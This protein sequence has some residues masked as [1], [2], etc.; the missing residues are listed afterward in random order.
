MTNEEVVRA[1]HIDW[2]AWEPC[3]ECGPNRFIMGDKYCCECG[4]PLTEEAWAEL[5]KRVK[6]LWHEVSD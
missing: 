1:A 5:E 6:G 3:S 4:R 2:E